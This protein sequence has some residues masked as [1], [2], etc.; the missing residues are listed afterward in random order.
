M[1]SL[2]DLAQ[3]VIEISGKS[4]RIVNVPGAMNVRGRNSSNRLMA[5]KLG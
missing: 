1:I 5:E 4:S 2:Q 3:L